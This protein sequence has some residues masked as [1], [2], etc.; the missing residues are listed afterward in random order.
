MASFDIYV[1]TGRPVRNVTV[2]IP[3]IYIKDKPFYEY[4]KIKDWDYRVVETRYE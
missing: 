2:I 4:V 1:Y 3:M